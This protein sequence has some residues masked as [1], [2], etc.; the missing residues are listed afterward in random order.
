MT[1]RQLFA[2]ICKSSWLKV[3]AKLV[4]K[5]VSGTLPGKDSLAL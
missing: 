4:T 5:Q 1:V 3:R 2:R